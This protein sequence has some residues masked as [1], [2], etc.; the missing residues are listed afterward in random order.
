MKDEL[1]SELKN[2]LGLDSNKEDDNTS[3][4]SNETD[5][6]VTSNETSNETDTHVFVPTTTNSFSS[7]VHD[8]QQAKRTSLKLIWKEDSRSALIYKVPNLLTCQL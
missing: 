8:E 5:T 7:T 2:D 3:L 4:T 1:S 6:P